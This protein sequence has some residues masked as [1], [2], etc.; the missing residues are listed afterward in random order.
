MTDKHLINSLN[1]TSNSSNIKIKVT[2]SCQLYTVC[3][4][5][6]P[7]FRCLQHLR[8]GR[9]TYFSRFQ[10]FLFIT[11]LFQWFHAWNQWYF[12]AI[13][14]ICLRSL[15]L[16]SGACQRTGTRPPS[17]LFLENRLY[18]TSFCFVKGFINLIHPCFSWFLF[19][20]RR[21][22]LITLV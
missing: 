2:Y 21:N 18:I 22:L 3:C 17:C 19:E 11:N 8:A 13:H 15:L 1:V 6:L 10:A 9:N 4:V 12:K 14:K 5:F 7:A 20:D 16:R